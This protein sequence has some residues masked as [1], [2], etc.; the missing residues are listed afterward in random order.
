[1]IVGAGSGLS[2]ALARRCAAEG[3]DVVLAIYGMSENDQSFVPPIPIY[4]IIRE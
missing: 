3:M 4:N 1:M 2:A